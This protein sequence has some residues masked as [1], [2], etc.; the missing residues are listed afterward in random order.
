VRVAESDPRRI[1]RS[2]A[3]R[4]ARPQ[5]LRKHHVSQSAVE[6]LEGGPA[7]KPTKA[8]YHALRRPPKLRLQSDIEAIATKLLELP[9]FQEQAR[10]LA[11]PLSTDAQLHFLSHA[12]SAR[13]P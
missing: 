12:R 13:G 4:A 8:L 5:V 10:P 1:A 11:G 3:H 7:S 2:T 6:A 9:F